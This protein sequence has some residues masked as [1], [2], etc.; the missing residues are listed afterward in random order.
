[1]ISRRNRPGISILLVIAKVADIV[2]YLGEIVLAIL[3][4]LKFYLV[5]D[6]NHCCLIKFVNFKHDYRL[7]NFLCLDKF[8]NCFLLLNIFFF[9]KIKKLDLNIYWLF[10]CE[11][12]SFPRKK[13]R[14][15]VN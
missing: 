13:G 2:K 8:W 15:W 3:L 12:S 4:Y 7:L 6:H 1:M 5:K 10:F 9:R 14:N 11:K